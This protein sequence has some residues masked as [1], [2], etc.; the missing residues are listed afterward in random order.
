MLSMKEPSTDPHYG[1]LRDPGESFQED[2][3]S[4]LNLH[5]VQHTLVTSTS[6]SKEAHTNVAL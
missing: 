3:Y 5:C 1:I 2:T 6:C 4:D